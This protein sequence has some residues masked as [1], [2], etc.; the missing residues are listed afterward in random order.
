MPRDL[1]LSFTHVGFSAD[2]TQ[3]IGG[4]IRD[5]SHVLHD[6]FLGSE[7]QLFLSKRRG[8]WRVDHRMGVWIT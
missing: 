3:A 7:H 8:T 2:R 5:Y 4:L 1:M 6:Q